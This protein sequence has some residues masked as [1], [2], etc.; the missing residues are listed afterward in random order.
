MAHLQLNF[1]SDSLQRNT[2]VMVFIPSAGPDDFLF[3]GAEKFNI[4]DKKYQVLYLLH[5]SYDDYGS[6]VRN[7]RIENYAQEKCMAVVMPSVENSAYLDM[8]WG[9]RYQTY[10]AGELP[11]FLSVL[12]PLSKKREDQFIAGLSMGGGGAFRFALTFPERYRA[13]ASLSGGLNMRAV[14][15][16]PHANKMPKNYLRAVYGETEPNEVIDL[17]ERIDPKTLP[18]LY[19]TCGTEDF[20]LPASETFYEQAVKKGVSV[21]YEKY[22]GVHNW[23]FWDVHIQDVLNWMPLAGRMVES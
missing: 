19:M 13:A 3:G 17:L 8:A 20:I 4:P 5:G 18:A 11:E 14:T 22:P 15:P 21:V 16:G 1:F 7:S 9:E 23:E 2:N 12:L 6:W 10:I